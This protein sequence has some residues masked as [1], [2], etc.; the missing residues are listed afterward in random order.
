LFTPNGKEII[1]TG[2]DKHFYLY[3]LMSGK[4]EKVDQVIGKLDLNLTA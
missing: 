2:T 4:V 3:E 1:A